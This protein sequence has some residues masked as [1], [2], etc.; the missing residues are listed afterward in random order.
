MQRIDNEWS[1]AY[2]HTSAMTCDNA[3]LL[4][5]A[6]ELVLRETD[7]INNALGIVDQFYMRIH[8]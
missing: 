8:A 4:T 6:M 1:F 7:K 2:I 5:E 3:I